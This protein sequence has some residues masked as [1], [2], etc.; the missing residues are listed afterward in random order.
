MTATPAGHLRVATLNVESL[1]DEELGQAVASLGPIDVLALQEVRTND[2]NIPQKLAEFA[3]HLDMRVA[4]FGLA[5]ECVGLGNALLVRS[6]LS[7][8]VV[9]GPWTLKHNNN[10]R[11]AESRCALAVT[12]PSQLRIVCTHLDHRSEAT[13]LAQLVQ[14]RGHMEDA[15]GPGF[16]QQPLLLLGDFNA[17]RR[18]DY[19]DARWQTLM[20]E[21]AESSIE[22]ETHV[23]DLLEQSPSNGGWSWADCRSVAASQ[24]RFHGDMATSVYG[25]RVDY[26]WATPAALLD[27]E[28]VGYRH[29][30]IGRMHSSNM[31]TDHAL[32][33]CELLD[34]AH[35]SQG[36]LPKNF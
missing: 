7:E 12:L 11:Y 36:T 31:L 9:H 19:S 16:E 25:A 34:R 35:E 32:V 28:I 33:L 22:S 10:S 1:R 24:S 14:L 23:T 8:V 20:R 13:R 6:N 21:R 29:A 2:Q 26:V 5:D 18:A 15:W 3:K 30:D 4:A 17:L 27:W